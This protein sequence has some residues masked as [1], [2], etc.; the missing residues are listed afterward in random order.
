M[1]GMEQ[2]FS[3]MEKVGHYTKLDEKRGFG[4]AEYYRIEGSRGN[5]GFIR[6]EMDSCFYCNR[7]RITP[8]GNIKIMPLF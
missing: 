6:N 5:I 7:I 8:H 4:P 3:I 1:I 2:I